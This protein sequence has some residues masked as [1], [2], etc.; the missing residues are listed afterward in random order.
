MDR[1]QDINYLLTRS[2]PMA[3]PG[4]E[5]DTKEERANLQFLREDASILCIGAGGLGCDLLKCMAL[6]GFKNI[7]VVD[8]DHIDATNLNR[9]FL[10]REKDVGSSKAKAASAFINKRVYDT[11]VNHFHGKM[12]EKSKEYYE[13]FNMIVCGLDSVPAR[14]WINSTLFSLLGY[15][16]EGNIDGDTIIPMID[17]GTEGFEGQVTVVYPG[18][19]ACIECN[20]RLFV[21]TDKVAICTVAGKPRKPAH[22]VLYAGLVAWKSKQKGTEVEKWG[23]PFVDENGKPYDKW[24]SDSPEHMTWLWKTAQAHAEKFN[25]PVKEV[26]Y[27]STKTVLKNTMPAIASTNALISAVATHEAFKLCTAAAPVLSNYMRWN[28]KRGIFTSNQKFVRNE[29]CTVCG[30]AV[31]TFPVDPQ[32]TLEDFFDLL[33]TDERFQFKAPT[34]SVGSEILYIRNPAVLERSYRPNLEKPLQELMKDGDKVIVTDAS[35]SSGSVT[36]TIKFE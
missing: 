2:S 17:A 15:D 33:Q 13:E 11:K 20:V 30:K 27:K 19:T 21:K 12:Q 14:R 9:Q 8:M 16:D 35:L 24:D 34:A 22:C 32:I 1:W 26:T 7:D 29:K 5:P 4:F 28:G 3:G 6:S 10:F 31:Y 18:N 23:K 25:L 36:L